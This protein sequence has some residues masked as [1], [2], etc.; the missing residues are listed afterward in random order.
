MNKFKREK[1]YM[2]VKITDA[3][4][5]LSVAEDQ[6]LCDLLLKIDNYRINVRSKDALTCAVI[7]HDWPEYELVWDMIQN[8]VEAEALKDGAK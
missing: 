8:R 7:E 1:R 5:A 3:V 4:N 2:V 6:Q